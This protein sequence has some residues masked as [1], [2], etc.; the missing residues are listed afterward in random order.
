V[1]GWG[2]LL[3]LFA[4]FVTAGQLVMIQWFL[5]DYDTWQVTVYHFTG[6]TL[7]VSALWLLQG[8]EWHVPGP[9]GWLFI[10]ALTLLGLTVRAAAIGAIRYIGSGQLA[11]FTPLSAFL[12]VVW[13]MLFLSEQF[14][15]VQWLGG[16][17]I[18]ISALLAIRRMR[19]ARRFRRGWRSW[20]RL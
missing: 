2:V 14:S 5:R 19:R 11:L 13:S 18:I 10:G 1:D 20:L 16:L 4:V 12:S 15:L 7:A 8:V 6:A 17:L 9:V 3:V